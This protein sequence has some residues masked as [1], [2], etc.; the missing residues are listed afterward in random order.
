[1]ILFESPNLEK[2]LREKD[3]QLFDFKSARLDHREVA[4][5][6]VAF[7]NADGGL[8]A[9]GIEKDGT[10]LQTAWN[11]CVPPMMIAHKF[12]DCVNHNGKADR[13]M[14]IEIAQD[15]RLDLPL[16]KLIDEAFRVVSSQLREF[17]RLVEDGIFE[18]TR[19]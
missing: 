3:D 13:I 17:T 15:I 19:L 11:L 4:A 14:L 18:T 7:A 2:I 6:F 9:I 10:I 1:M 8:L 16:P 12:V 5:H